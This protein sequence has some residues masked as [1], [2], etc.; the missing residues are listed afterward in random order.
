[1]Q[2]THVVEVR[3]NDLSKE[4]QEEIMKIT[5][6]EPLKNSDKILAII[7]IVEGFDYHRRY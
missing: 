5:N 2:G 7:T 1:M 3:F 6:G 4:K